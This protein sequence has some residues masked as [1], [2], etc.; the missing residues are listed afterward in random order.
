MVKIVQPVKLGL[1]IQQNFDKKKI[2]TSRVANGARPFFFTNQ[3]Q[4]DKRPEDE[5]SVG[6]Q[7]NSLVT[8]NISR[9]SL[10][11]AFFSI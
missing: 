10:N 4:K 6:V 5:N 9:K 2:N 11:L 3:Y 1:A 7:I 8:M